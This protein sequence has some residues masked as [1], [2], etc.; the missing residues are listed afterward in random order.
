MNMLYIFLGVLAIILF[1]MGLIVDYIQKKMKVIY[2]DN[3]SG[4][5]SDNMIISE[6]CNTSDEVFNRNIEVKKNN[7]DKGKINFID[8]EIL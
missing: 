8:D 6:E 4:V 5:S 3:V 7:E 1:I 2:S